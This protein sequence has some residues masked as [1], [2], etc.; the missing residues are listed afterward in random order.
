MDEKWTN[1]IAAINEKMQSLS[2]RIKDATETA[3][4]TGMVTADELNTKIADV[5]SNLIAMQEQLRIESEKSQAK[6]S[7]H[8]LQAQ[9]NIEEVKKDIQ[10]KRD[11]H[12]KEKME[13]FVAD[14][15]EYA[16]ECQTLAELL[17]EEAKLAT[18]EANN[19]AAEYKEK[20]N[21]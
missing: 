6:L 9:M 1:S 17:I 15:L 10:S 3:Q 20:Y 21:K 14:M 18:L 5:K 11:T 4:I 13:E 19:A 8:V 2:E 12:D 7:S 16:S